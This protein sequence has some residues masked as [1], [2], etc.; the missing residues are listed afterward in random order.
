LQGAKE[1]GR[2]TTQL[3]RNIEALQLLSERIKLL[4]N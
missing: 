2:N 1:Q 3:E 4:D